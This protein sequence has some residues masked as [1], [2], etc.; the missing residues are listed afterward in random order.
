MIIEH[1]LVHVGDFAIAPGN[2]DGM[3]WISRIDAEGYGEGGDFPIV[4][5]EEV[6]RKFYEERF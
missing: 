6:I 5:L 4:E 3:V 1:S 2:E